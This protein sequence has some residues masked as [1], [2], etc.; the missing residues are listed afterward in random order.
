MKIVTYIHKGKVKHYSID[1]L[2]LLKA[3]LTEEW[4]KVCHNCGKCCF[5]KSIS[6]KGK[7]FI[8]Y[9]K[10]CQHLT[11]LGKASR[12]AVYAKRFDECKECNTIPE[13]VSK[14]YLPHDCP[15]TK[16]VVGYQPP[17]DNNEWYKTSKDKIINGEPLSKAEAPVYS[18]PT[19]SSMSVPPELKTK[20]MELVREDLK[21]PKEWKR[22][23]AER[24][25][26]KQGG[27]VGIL[28][29][30][31]KTEYKIKPSGHALGG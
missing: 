30:R 17:I 7:I 25:K 8:N 27:E 2:R 12:C 18:T 24:I 15:Y 4:E 21:K 3:H 10:P 11:F 31:Q 28:D 20:E 1:E 9:N 29:P 16:S 23:R 26:A 19:N 13:A 14:R 22:R 6:Q 5:D